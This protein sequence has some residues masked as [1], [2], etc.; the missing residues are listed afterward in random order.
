LTDKKHQNHLILRPTFFDALQA[1]I[2]KA[3]RAFIFSRS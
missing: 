1:F 2:Y 3:R